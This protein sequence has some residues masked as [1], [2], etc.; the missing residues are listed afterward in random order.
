MFIESDT[1]TVNRER[2]NEK[3]VQSLRAPISH[4]SNRHS[5]TLHRERKDPGGRGG[6]EQGVRPGCRQTQSPPQVFPLPDRSKLESNLVEEQRVHEF[7]FRECILLHNI[8]V[9]FESSLRNRGLN[10]LS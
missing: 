7:L 9:V 8:V 10:L 6:G 1:S 3:K 4:T 2:R 5:S